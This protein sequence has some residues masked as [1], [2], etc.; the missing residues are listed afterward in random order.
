M[1]DPNLTQAL[2]EAYASATVKMRIVHTI[3]ISHPAFDKTV[4]VVADYRPDDLNEKGQQKMS[5]ILETGQQVDFLC[6]AFE[7]DMPSIDTTPIPE[8]VLTIDN[9]GRELMASLQKASQSNDDVLVKYRAYTLND[10]TTPA[11]LR[12]L[13]FILRDVVVTPLQMSGICKVKTVGN[14]SFPSE[15]YTL[16][17]YVGLGN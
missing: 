5:A 7:L 4:Y 2:Q 6:F 17:D 3:E 9:V 14:N 1:T 8:L 11:M 16:S 13:Q 12:P 15:K 10:L